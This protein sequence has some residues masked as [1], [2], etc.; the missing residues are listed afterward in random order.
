MTLLGKLEAAE[1]LMIEASEELKTWGDMSRVD[2]VN[3]ACN[4]VLRV[5]LGLEDG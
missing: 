4:A 3:D 2:E 5:R 1:E